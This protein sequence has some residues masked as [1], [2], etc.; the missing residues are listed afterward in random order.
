[1]MT[2]H[3]QS[4]PRKAVYPGSHGH[5]R[6][7]PHSGHGKADCLKILRR[8]SAYVDEELP[9]EI[10][11]EIRKHMGFCPNC[12]LF[13]TSLQQTVRLCHHV[14]PRPLS[15]ALKSRIRRSILQAIGRT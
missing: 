8:L 3:V 14:E 4:Q 13:V 10:C 7:A 1:M 6:S 15:P 2:R 11:K 12:E 9:S 5:N